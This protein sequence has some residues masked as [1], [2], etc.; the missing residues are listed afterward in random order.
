MCIR[1]LPPTNSSITRDEAGREGGKWEGQ[2]KDQRKEER[3]R[4]ELQAGGEREEGSEAGRG[5][6][7]ER[8]NV[9]VR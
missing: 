5:G 6:R 2:G 3:G 4:E 8:R 7:R 9:R 1:H